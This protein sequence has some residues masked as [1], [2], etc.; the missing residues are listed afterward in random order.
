[1]Q[2]E[3]EDDRPIVMQLAFEVIDLVHPP[4]EGFLPRVFLHLLGDCPAVPAP[5]KEGDPP[6]GR[7]AEPEPP[8]ERVCL[9]FLG[10]LLDGVEG[11][12]PGVEGVDNLVDGHG[13]PRSVPAFDD[14]DGGDLLVTERA[15][16]DT[17]PVFQRFEGLLVRSLIGC[18]GKIEFVE[19]PS[20]FPAGVRF[21]GCSIHTF[22]GV[23]GR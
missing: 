6:F 17:E 22:V 3:L 1:M 16:E 12:P 4:P 9:L 18:S 15:L 8:E 14:N 7:D 10:G 21:M 23:D 19:H 20:Q 2:E 5:G 11:I 13:D